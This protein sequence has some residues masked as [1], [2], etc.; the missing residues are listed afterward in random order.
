MSRKLKEL[1]KR[2]KTIKYLKF[3]IKRDMNEMREHQ[4]ERLIMQSRYYKLNAE[5][6]LILAEQYKDLA[7]HY[8]KLSEYANEDY[9]RK[10]K[11]L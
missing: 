1:L 5:Q 2:N 7:N 10:T 3:C 9:E 6:E 8:R 11:T 4:P